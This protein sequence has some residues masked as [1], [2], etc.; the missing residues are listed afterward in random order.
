[1]CLGWGYNFLALQLCFLICKKGDHSTFH[2]ELRAW[3][4]VNT[5]IFLKKFT[6]RL[7]PLLRPFPS[8]SFSPATVVRFC[9]PW[10]AGSCKFCGASPGLQ[11]VVKDSEAKSEWGSW[12]VLVWKLIRAH[13][14]HTPDSMQP[15]GPW[16]KRPLPWILP[17]S[18]A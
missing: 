2:V 11:P 10:E 7:T 9:V 18:G 15:K 4:T 16:L 14:E 1:M 5:C 12:V 17:Q 6:R 8:I 3:R 13:S